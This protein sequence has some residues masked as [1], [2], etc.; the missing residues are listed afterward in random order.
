MIHPIYL[1]L[2][3]TSR[4]RV[5]FQTVR[6]G[7][8]DRNWVFVSREEL[9]WVQNSDGG[10]VKDWSSDPYAEGIVIQLDELQSFIEQ[11][12]RLDKLVVMK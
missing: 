4:L 12:A 1:Q 3:D 2:T 7:V 9:D 5:V 10:E 6:N 11:V 8:E